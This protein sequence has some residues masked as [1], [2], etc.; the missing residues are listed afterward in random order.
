MDE[1]KKSLS[2]KIT[3]PLSIIIAGLLIA[4]GIYLNGRITK[5]NPTVTQKQQ[6]V[7]ENLLNILRP[8]DANDHVLGSPKARILVVEYSDTECP[9]CKNFHSTMLS[10]MQEYGKDERVA[11][12]YRHYP[13][14]ELHSKSFKESEALE[15]AGNLGGNSKFWEYTDKVY[16]VT[17]SNDSLDPKEL[18]NIATEVGL[19]STAF[20]TCLDSGEFDPR[21]N[22]DIKNAKELGISGTPYSVIIDTKANKS[23]PIEGAYPYD[24]VKSVIDLI[25]QS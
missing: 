14:A 2:D 3:L 8:I 16:E 25:L 1:N 20:N 12:V 22:F 18:T 10:I 15:C 21:I 17:N 11:W 4:G 7:S 23:Y 6:L 5:I 13:I 9:Y 24:Q 19:S